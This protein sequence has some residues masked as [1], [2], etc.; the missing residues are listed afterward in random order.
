MMPCKL[1][2]CILGA[3]LV[4]NACALQG[5]GPKALKSLKDANPNKDKET[6]K[7]DGSAMMQRTAKKEASDFSKE[8]AQFQAALQAVSAMAEKQGRTLEE[9]HQMASEYLEDEEL[10]KDLE[11][12]IEEQKQKWVWQRQAN[13]DGPQ[14]YSMAWVMIA[15]TDFAS[16]TYV[17]TE[18]GR[19]KLSED[20]TFNPTPTYPATDSTVY[21]QGDGYF[22]GFFSAISIQSSYVLLD[23]GN[24]EI[25]MSPEFHKSQRF[26]ALIETASRPFIPG[27]GP[28][29]LSSPTM[30]PSA[31]IRSANH[32]TIRHC[33]FGLSSHHSIHGNDNNDI[34]V[35]DSFFKDFEVGAIA[36]NNC[37]GAMIKRCDIGGS[38]ETTWHAHLSQAILLRHMTLNIGMEES[39]GGA[40]L[41]N[42][43]ETTMVTLRGEAPRSA[44]DIVR[45]LDTAVTA[46]I[47]SADDSPS[48]D[49]ADLLG[50]KVTPD[51]SA[52]YG[53]LLHK[54]KPAAGEFG[55]CPMKEYL[56]GSE[57]L[58]TRTK[59]R[60]VVIHDLKL[61][62]EAWISL[63]KFQDD[64]TTKQVQGPAGAVFR[65]TH[66]EATPGGAYQGNILSDAQ[67]AVA[68]VADAAA[69][70]TSDEAR[71]RAADYYPGA[72]IPTEVQ[73]W[74]AAAAGSLDT[75]DTNTW[76]IK[77]NGDAMSH[78][79]K[80]I[81]G[82]RLGYQD[83]PNM[84]PISTNIDAPAKA[85]QGKYWAQRV[86]AMWP[87]NGNYNDDYG[88]AAARR[89]GI[90]LRDFTNSGE[91]PE[92]T[93]GA[94][95]CTPTKYKGNDVRG[96]R[97]TNCIDVRGVDVDNL[98]PG[99]GGEHVNYEQHET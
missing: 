54:T 42:L 69:T 49:L 78:H 33:S 99:E 70:G 25:K 93:S 80:G 26:F 56:N 34:F 64:G 88:T 77:C 71:Q 73:T 81:V 1:S 2:L 63:H 62:P 84:G 15:Q 57:P 83:Q 97:L 9:K 68:M 85:A 10:A 52:M 38:L 28:P 27:A 17:I 41:K 20:I 21:L 35:R 47:S 36:F 37:K 96:F 61:K 16:G 22:L 95:S 92:R 40:D 11:R 5:V 72:Y 3:A 87:E 45:D 58:I 46:F 91:G 65:F 30:N 48:G 74:A 82:I 94:S 31:E 23:C 59:I 39:L 66:W 18:P 89:R 79:N 67:I 51:G 90:I 76:K 4:H 29:P 14:V 75:S 60:W 50:T 43:F 8:N 53:I 19:Y 7:I 13:G 86:V 98:V 24:K 12:K 55:S 6:I 32:T 44:A